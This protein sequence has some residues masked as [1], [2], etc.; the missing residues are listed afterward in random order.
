MK[1]I[2]HEGKVIGEKEEA[3]KGEKIKLQT[4]E[5][6]GIALH[7]TFTVESINDEEVNVSEDPLLG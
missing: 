2:I 6:D 7:K 3:K 5:Q 4:G 1:K